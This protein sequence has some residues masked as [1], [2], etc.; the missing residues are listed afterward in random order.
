[1]F[2]KKGKNLFLPGQFKLV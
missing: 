2:S 1:M